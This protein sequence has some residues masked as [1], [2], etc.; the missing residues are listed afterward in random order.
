MKFAK[1][2]LGAMML[3][4]QVVFSQTA[5][6]GIPEKTEIYNGSSFSE[7][8]SKV[9]QEH[10]QT[11]P[12]FKLVSSETLKSLASVLMNAALD[13]KND[14]RQRRVKLIH[15]NGICLVGT[16][17]V[18]QDNNYSGYFAKNSKALVVARAS[19]TQDYIYSDDYRAFGLAVKLFPTLDP[20][21]KVFTSNLFSVD[22]IPGIKNMHFTETLMT[23]QIPDLGFNVAVL[24]R[25]VS[26]MPFLINF[27]SLSQK[28][29]TGPEDRNPLLRR[30]VEV[31]RAGITREYSAVSQSKNLP[32]YKESSMRSEVKE[33]KWIGFQA[34]TMTETDTR[35]DFRDE[36][37]EVVQK[38]GELK[39]KILTADE[40][41]RDGAQIW[42]Q[43]GT[44]TFT[45]AVASKPC[46]MDLHFRHPRTDD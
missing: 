24:L 18:N 27:S 5:P 12:H 8:W 13:N 7:V 19:A 3:T 16:W 20:N 21:E 42:Q 4:T 37:S 33:P 15:P 31:A 11:L 23:N 6:S 34:E 40:K 10:Y 30:T 14:F 25:L 43:L 28:A 38:N 17:E 32:S 9:D 45:Q 2:T 39:Y 44:I 46:D 35:S 41:D 22:N 26:K 36:I 29:D 1:L